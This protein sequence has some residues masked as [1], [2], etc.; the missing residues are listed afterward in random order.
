LPSLGDQ[1]A[2]IEIS[3][4]PL[5][6][7]DDKTVII[8]NRNFSHY[9]ECQSTDDLKPQV[10]NGKTPSAIAGCAEGAPLI[11]RHGRRPPIDPN[12]ASTEL[13]RTHVMPENPIDWSQCE[14]V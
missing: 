11:A 5:L 4:L 10:D 13:E 9:I 8:A 1:C 2:V 7:L 12:L 6:I 3:I 14:D